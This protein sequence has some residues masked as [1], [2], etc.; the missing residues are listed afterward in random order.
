MRG[1]A[2]LAYLLAR[3]SDT[4]AD[5]AAAPPEMRRECLEH[6]YHALT[7]TGNSPRWPLAMIRAVD[8]TRE[9]LLLESQ[10]LLFAWLGGLPAGEAQLVREVVGIII[11]GQ[12]LD[13]DRFARADG[14]RPVRLPDDAAL[15]DYTWRVAGCVGAFWTKLGLL[16]ME[17]RFSQTPA[18]VLLD[19]G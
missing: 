17:D 9:K 14:A 5:T 16:T 1:A 4:L 2:S 19:W 6:F 3:T 15:E 7:E 10:D 13:L 12:R 8:D 11:G 18:N